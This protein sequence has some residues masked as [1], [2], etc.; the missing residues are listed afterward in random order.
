MGL[1]IF[2]Y[3]GLAGLGLY[4]EGLIYG[5]KSIGLS[6]LVGS[7]LLCFTL[8][9]EGWFNGGF[10]ASPVWGAY[11]WRGL[12]SEFCGSLSNHRRTIRTVRGIVM[13]R[14]TCIFRNSVACVTAGPGPPTRLSLRK[15]PYVPSGEERG[16]TDAFAGYTRLNHLYSPSEEGLESL[17][18]RQVTPALGLI[19]VTEVFSGVGEGLWASDR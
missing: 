8:Y 9:L 2:L 7:I 3:Q 17:R 16:E 11:I 12:F 13:S 4:S 5:R 15:H 1:Q 10:F 19:Q 6:L 14:A 18:R